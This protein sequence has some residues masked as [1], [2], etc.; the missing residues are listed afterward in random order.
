MDCQDLMVSQGMG[1]HQATLVLWAT[2]GKLVQMGER[3]KM[4][5]MES[6]VSVDLRVR[7]GM[8]DM[9]VLLGSWVDLGRLGALDHKESGAS[10]EEKVQSDL[11]ASLVWQAN[12]VQTGKM[13]RQDL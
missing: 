1:V 5:G 10:L 2:A 13:V 6:M 12:Q 8:T 9:M 7:L 4:P 3:E 11:T